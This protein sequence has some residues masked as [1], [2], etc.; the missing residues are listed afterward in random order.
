VNFMLWR[1]VDWVMLVAGLGASA[2]AAYFLARWSLRW[3]VVILLVIAGVVFLLVLPAR[4]PSQNFLDTGLPAL[5]FNYF[6]A[7]VLAFILATVFSVVYLVRAVR[8]ARPAAKVVATDAELAGKYPELEAAWEE[9]QVQL[10]QAQID[11]GSQHTVLLLAPDEEGSAALVHSA[12][13]HLFAE[14][15]GG[16]APMHAYATADGLLLSASGGSAF[17]TQEVDGANRLE[18]LCRR[19]LA[20][21]PELPIVRGVVVQFPIRWA[22]QPDSIKWAAAV[23]DDLGAIRRALKVRC[24]VFALFT[25]METV[26]GFTEFVGRMA[27]PLR[28][29]RC[30]FA[31][32]G[33]Q[34]FSGDLV[35]RGLVW[36]SGWF[37]GWILNQMAEGLFNQAG[38]SE[39]FGL[40]HELRRYRKRLRSV[41]EASFA[42]HRE[43]EPVVFRGCYFVGTGSGPNEQ[44][45]SAGLL[46]GAR[47]RIFADHRATE[48]TRQAREDDHHDRR[49]ALGVGLAGGLL[50]LLAWIY[51]LVKT[52]ESPLWWAW[53]AGPIVVAVAWIVAAVRISRW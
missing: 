5:F 33:T 30:G 12:G 25:Q 26:P 9:I 45:F 28:Q 49:I 2:V 21:N 11:L 48:W 39:L 38:N 36:M 31:V 16:A 41:L 42:T 3:L 15:P 27:G 10:G 6:W 51:I 34:P 24:P 32:P 23:R 22:G 18:A 8:K 20:K 7:W 14:A 29:S 52:A 50:T 44:A 37:H 46:R 40:G 53:W 4:Y 35:Q 47:G 43:S 13:L 1:F 17:G 19:L